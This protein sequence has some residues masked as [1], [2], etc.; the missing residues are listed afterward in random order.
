MSSWDDALAL[1]KQQRVGP[2]VRGAVYAQ[3]CRCMPVQQTSAPTQVAA[4]CCGSY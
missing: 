4:A 1:A 2:G 3:C